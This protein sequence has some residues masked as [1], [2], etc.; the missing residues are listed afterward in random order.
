M[1]VLKK[2]A[3]QTAIYGI[4]SILGRVLNLALTPLYTNEAYSGFGEGAYGIMSSLYSFI[5]LMNIIL[6]LEWKRPFSAFLRM[7]RI[8]RLFIIRLISGLF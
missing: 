6:I 5:A 4:S 8:S 3:G 2:L 7:T 1:G